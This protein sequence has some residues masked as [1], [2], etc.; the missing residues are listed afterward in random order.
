MWRRH[1]GTGVYN[2]VTGKRAILCAGSIIRQAPPITMMQFLIF[3]P[4]SEWYKLSCC[5]GCNPL[6]RL[7]GAIYPTHLLL[8]TERKLRQ[9]DPAGELSKFLNYQILWC[10]SVTSFTIATYID[11]APSLKLTSTGH[12]QP[13]I[14]ESSLIPLDRFLPA[15]VDYSGNDKID[16]WN[17]TLIIK[18]CR[19]GTRLRQTRYDPYLVGPY[20]TQTH[21][22]MTFFLHSFGLV[23]SKLLIAPRLPLGLVSSI[24][25]IAPSNI[26]KKAIVRLCTEEKFMFGLITLL[27][28]AWFIKLIKFNF[29]FTILY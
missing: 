2:R 17:L 4:A 10:T 3:P 13:S 6:A 29:Y 14:T 19:F 11:T 24:A 26:G 7:L 25:K 18:P 5:H 21:S 22:Y 20:Q 1:A 8:H 16:Q 12:S 15:V 23:L 9:P 28:Y 27:G